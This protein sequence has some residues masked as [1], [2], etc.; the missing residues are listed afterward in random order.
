M[1]KRI[2]AGP[3]H[4]IAS[5]TVKVRG[6]HGCTV[7]STAD[8]AAGQAACYLSS[9]PAGQV[10]VFYSEQCG[11]CRGSGRVS[12]NRRTLAWMPCPVCAGA[13]ET[14]PDTLLVTHTRA[15]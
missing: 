12:K 9:R 4:S 2:K 14:T 13:A 1:T 5:F 7:C 6:E 15:S 10:D 11:R 3:A 8:G